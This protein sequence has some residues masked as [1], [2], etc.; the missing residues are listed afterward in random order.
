MRF[1]TIVLWKRC[2]DCY[3][4]MIGLRVGSWSVREVC[5]DCG[6][7]SLANWLADSHIA[8][9]NLK[10]AGLIQKDY[11]FKKANEHDR[12]QDTASAE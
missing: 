8:L 11:Q 9:A 7:Q 2:A 6:G 5:V 4:P 3:T 1:A 10:A 12:A